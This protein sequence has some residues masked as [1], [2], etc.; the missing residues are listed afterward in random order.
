MTGT[1]VVE[2]TPERTLRVDAERRRQALLCAA[3][4]VFL[5][6]GL[7]AP[8][9]SVAAAAGVGIATLYRRFPTRDALVEAV[10]EA[11][12]AAHADRIEA[13]AQ[14]AASRPWAAFCEYV[15]DLCEM[16]VADPAFGRVLLRPMQGSPLFADAHARAVRA[17]RRLVSRAR[18]AGALR[19]EVR[20]PDLY[21]LTAS[22]AAL[23][24]DPGPMSAERAACRLTELFLDAVKGP[25]A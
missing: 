11:K 14:R 21:L 25:A 3:A 22:I 8:L 6:E 5:A 16:Q 4:S 1:G 17:S 18:K 13:A 10:F 19:A 23:I 12:M 2:V 20:E 24:A 9:E 15:R 7:D